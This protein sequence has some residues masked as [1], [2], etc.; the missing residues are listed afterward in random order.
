MKTGRRHAGATVALAVGLAASA[1][2]ATITVNATADSLAVDGNCTLREA[3]IAANTDA[4]V[5][6]CAP[7]SGADVVVLP[8]GTYV[9]TLVGA[10]EDAAATGDL[11]ITADLELTG[12]G[13]TTTVI[14]GN[15]TDRV[16]DVDPA[17]TGLSVRVSGV[18]IQNGGGVQD[19]GGV[20]N[21]GTLVVVDSVVQANTA[22]ASG[23]FPNP[24][25]AVGGGI[26]SGGNLRL[27]RCVLRDNA[28]E[29]LGGLGSSAHGG[30]ISAGV[31]DVIDSTITANRA[32]VGLSPNGSA[33]GGGIGGGSLMLVGSTVSDNEASAENGP[34]PP[35]ATAT[36]RGGGIAVVGGSTIRNSTIS[37]N[38][39]SSSGGLSGGGGVDVSAPATVSF[40]N[41]TV[42]ANLAQDVEA[43]GT[44]ATLVFRNSILGT[45]NVSFGPPTIVGDAYNIDRFN[46][47]GLSDSDQ[48]GL[49]PLLGP[50]QDNGGPTFTHAPLLGSPAVNTGSPAA[51]GS[52]G[53]ACE[54]TDQVGVVRPI[55]PV[56]DV[57]A[58]ESSL[59]VTTT[60][61]T[62]TTTLPALCSTAP[63]AGCQ[64]ALGEKAK[65][66]LKN[67]SDDAKDRLSWSWTSSAAVPAADFENPVE[68]A[69]DYT[70]CLYDQTRFLVGA[71]AP[72]G[73]TCG[74]R[75]CWKRTGSS[76][77]VYRDKLLDPDGLEKIV[78]KPG[79]S[80]GK[81]KIAVNGKGANLALP[82]LGLTTPVRVQLLRSMSTCWEATFSAAS[83]NDA[84]AFKARSDP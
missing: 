1:H 16:L 55:G 71:A 39:A 61:S 58:V 36:A 13:A 9:L 79:A 29:A 72:A 73:G 31:L 35:P 77:L 49:D 22:A 53:T 30:G 80:A 26:R 68:G 62:T 69:N 19:G 17:A 2:G 7:G 51:P 48:P 32:R 63:Q 34:P 46:T 15:G 66:T 27:E 45:C 70:L 42:W 84:E 33:T 18:T 78:L 23:S 8:A 5:D 24:A 60:T 12:A 76:T 74:T 41:A 59:G 50:L 20:R 28:A 57:G 82:A 21:R 52:G 75:P 38:T 67:S 44:L 40:F 4:A 47:C 65:L 64:P 37:G 56:C 43:G 3:I 10:G 83:R 81:A 11:D 54:A 6:A 25:S 14:D